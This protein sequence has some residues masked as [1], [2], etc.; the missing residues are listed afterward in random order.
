[1]DPVGVV[2]LM[3]GYVEEISTCVPWKNLMSE[4]TIIK[5]RGLEL[6][7][8][9][10]SDIN[11]AKTQELGTFD[12]SKKIE[13]FYFSLVS[14]MIGSIASSMDLARSVIA[15]EQIASGVENAGVEQFA[16]LIDQVISRIKV[17]FEDVII[18][19][20]AYSDV[21]TGLEIQIDQ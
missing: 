14:S 2:S 5:I 13:T 8:T 7:L 10:L 4:S 15:D 11:M 16:S 1:M 17:I 9:P 19:V 20:E 18:R 21:C 6:T 3:E 12:F